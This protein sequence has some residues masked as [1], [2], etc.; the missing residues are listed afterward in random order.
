MGDRKWPPRPWRVGRAYDLSGKPW[1]WFEIHAGHGLNHTMVADLVLPDAA[2][3]I[4]AAP[5]LYEALFGIV[6]EYQDCI[7]YDDLARLEAVLAKA[8]GEATA[9]E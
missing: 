9:N 2:D 1:W 8:R 7:G 5:D 3:L 6:H 4:V